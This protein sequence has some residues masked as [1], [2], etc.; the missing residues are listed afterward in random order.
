MLEIN[1]I[2]HSINNANLEEKVC[3]ALSLTGTKVKLEDLD[4]YKKE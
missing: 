3:K 4:A 1:L 2:P